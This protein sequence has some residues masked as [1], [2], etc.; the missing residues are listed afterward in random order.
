MPST[1][2]YLATLMCIVSYL[3]VFSSTSPLSLSVCE[4]SLQY[5]PVLH[6]EEPAAPC[7][8]PSPT[9]RPLIDLQSAIAKLSGPA[10][11]KQGPGSYPPCNYGYSVLITK[12]ACDEGKVCVCLCGINFS[13]KALRILLPSQ[14]TVACPY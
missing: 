10:R 2:G 11:N 3:K 12:H 13:T 6:G 5:A 4:Y 8:A 1:M 14:P 9:I 7:S